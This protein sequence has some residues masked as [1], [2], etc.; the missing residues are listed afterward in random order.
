VFLA[1]KFNWSSGSIFCFNT[2]SPTNNVGGVQIGQIASATLKSAATS[3]PITLTSVPTTVSGVG[4]FLQ[5]VVSGASGFPGTIAITGTNLAGGT[6]SENITVS[7]NTTYTSVNSYVTVTNL[8]VA[9]ITGYSINIIG[10]GVPYAGSTFQSGGVTTATA[11]FAYNIDGLY[12]KNEWTNGTIWFCNDGGN[13]FVRGPVGLETNAN[14]NKV[15]SGSAHAT[16]RISL[17]PNGVTADGTSA[18]GGQEKI[19]ISANKALTV[20]NATGT[21]YMNVNTSGVRFELPN[22]AVFRQ[23]SDN[24]STRSTELSGGTLSVLQSTSAAAT[25]SSGTITTSGVGVARVAPTG[26]ITGV[27]L[28]AGTL[29]G[30]TIFVVNE[31]AFTVTFAASSSNVADAATSAIPANSARHFVWDSSTSLWYRVA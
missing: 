17:V 20:S 14:P 28:Q 27:V 2:G 29:A 9:T 18:K 1:G 3:S 30:Q 10:L 12:S 11:P 5:F 23:Y 6:I 26:N 7:A 21:E 24:Y 16:T 22:A 4:A 19:G 8:T 13:G 15:L 31:S 25:A